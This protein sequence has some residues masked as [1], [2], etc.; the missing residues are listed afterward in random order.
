MCGVL[1]H[2]VRFIV[3]PSIRAYCFQLFQTH[4]QCFALQITTQQPYMNVCVYT[5]KQLARPMFLYLFTHSDSWSTS[6]SFY[7][8][9]YFLFCFHSFGCFYFVQYNCSHFDA[10]SLWHLVLCVNPLLIFSILPFMTP[11]YYLYRTRRIVIADVL[12]PCLISTTIYTPNF[13]RFIVGVFF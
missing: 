6:S 5:P 3:L 2:I 9:F 4:Y 8:D 11:Q 12:W 13:I 7:F 10:A 1:T